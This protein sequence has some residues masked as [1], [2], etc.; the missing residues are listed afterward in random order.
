MSRYLMDPVSTIV[1]SPTAFSGARLIEQRDQRTTCQ[2]RD[3]F[4]THYLTAISPIKQQLPRPT[5]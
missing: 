5:T 1:T 4:M 2:E 3:A